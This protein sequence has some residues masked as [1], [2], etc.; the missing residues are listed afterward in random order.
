MPSALAEAL[1]AHA[2]RAAPAECVGLLFGRRVDGRVTRAAP[3]SNHASTPQTTFFAAPQELFDALQGAAA[4]T[5][6]LL[7]IYHSHPHGP[8]HPSATDVAAARYPA[9][10]VIVAWGELRAF[11]LG[12]RG[13]AEV[14]L[15][16][17][18]PEHEPTI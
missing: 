13:A 15:E 3:L 2:R 6:D 9:L 4:R 11:E 5:E 18:D 16:L 1:R 7:A 8:P 12:P 17:I 14:R 10:C